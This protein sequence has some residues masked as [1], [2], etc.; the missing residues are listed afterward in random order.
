MPT[1]DP[2]D[3][4]PTFSPSWWVQKMGSMT[5][6]PP[7]LPLFNPVAASAP[8]GLSDNAAGT[9]M[10]PQ[11]DGGDQ[12][13]GGILSP[14]FASLQS[15]SGADTGQQNPNIRMAARTDDTSGPVSFGGF[16]DPADPRHASN[17][18]E[19]A[20]CLKSRTTTSAEIGT[21]YYE[22]CADG[23][24]IPLEQTQNGL[25]K[26]FLIRG[27][28]HGTQVYGS[29]KKTGAYARWG[30]EPGR[31]LSGSVDDNDNLSMDIK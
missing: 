21:G 18:S 28:T 3:V 12:G 7:N 8:Q 15:E 10:Q 1:R 25:I 6:A 13:G 4:D 29:D 17:K 11:S 31:T 23:R 14:Y 9:V 19:F 26:R 24:L 30:L 27:G 20:D 2:W 22:F 16:V 5:W